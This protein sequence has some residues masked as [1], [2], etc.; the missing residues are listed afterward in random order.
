MPLF[1]KKKGRDE[2]REG[3]VVKENLPPAIV[4]DPADRTKLTFH[5]QL[6]QGSPTGVIS[7]FT[8]VKELYQKIGEVY[9][10]DPSEILFCTLNTHK[11]NMNKLLGAQIALTDFIFAHKKGL[12]KE[13]ELIKSEA[14]LGLTI[15]DN[16]SGLAFIKRIKEDSVIDG[17]PV[18]QVGDHIER[19]NNENLVGKRHYEVAKCIRDLP[20]GSAFTIRLVSPLQAG[21]CNIGPRGER[22]KSKK[23]GYGSGKQ[24]LRFKA[25]GAAVVEIVDDSVDKAVTG[26][27]NVLENYLGI[28]DSDLALQIWDA[29]EGCDNSVQFATA[30]DSC[31]L[32]ELQFSDDVIIDMWGVVTDA[33]AQRL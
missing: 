29:G 26:I 24:T 15:T 6:A 17:V 2:E 14:A 21:F 10:F 31:D 18:I 27:N 32:G 3:M 19:I 1:P 22:G 7:G 5:C 8:N 28:S 4:E 20:L 30:I 16:G 23:S 13:V 25:G 33:R 11:I 9:D 12:R